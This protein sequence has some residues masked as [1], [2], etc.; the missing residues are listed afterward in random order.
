MSC[1][2]HAIRVSAALKYINMNTKEK[3]PKLHLDFQLDEGFAEKGKKPK[4]FNDPWIFRYVSVNQHYLTNKPKP[5]EVLVSVLTVW[6]VILKQ[7]ATRD[8]PK[9]PVSHPV[10]IISNRLAGNTETG[11]HTGILKIPMS[12]PVLVIAMT[13]LNI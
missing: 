11:R 4:G 9:C 7:A 2:C 5:A 3:N 6:R 8:F 1:N 10:S 12:H 13:R